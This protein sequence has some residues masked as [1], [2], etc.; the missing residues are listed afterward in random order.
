MSFNYQNKLIQQV[1]E[2]RRMVVAKYGAGKCRVGL[3]AADILARKDSIGGLVLILCPPRNVR[4]WITQ[5]RRWIPNQCPTLERDV[6]SPQL[7]QHIRQKGTDNHFLIL[8]NTRLYGNLDTL[9]YLKPDVII[10]DESTV[11]KN[12]KT[13]FFG[14]AMALVKAVPDAHRIAMTGDPTPE[15]ESEIW[16]Q[17]QFCY[18]DRNPYGRTYYQFMNRWFIRSDFVWTIRLEKS[19]EFMAVFDRYSCRMDEDDVAEH[20]AEVGVEEQ[21]QVF[22]YKPST[23]QMQL[24]EGLQREWALPIVVGAVDKEEYWHSISILH[25]QM[26]IASGFY[27]TKG[28]PLLEK[29]SPH[30]LPLAGRP[31]QV[32]LRAVVD[33]LLQNDHKRIVI[34]H[35]YKAD[36]A[37]ITAGLQG[38]APL[39][40]TSDNL[41]Q[42]AKEPKD[43]EEPLVIVL[44]LASARG[45]NDLTTASADIFFSNSFSQEVRNQAEKRLPRPGQTNRQVLHIDLAANDLADYKVV[46][47]LQTKQM[48]PER[49][50]TIVRET[51]EQT[52]Q[53]TKQ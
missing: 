8:A 3:L 40:G 1:V 14:N 21:Y 6:N 4:T 7:T 2:G 44:S 19:A 32:K 13:R 46:L 33:W 12:H 52:F 24:L 27:Y 22:M 49:A 34:W 36:L 11:M 50:N 15:H 23:L 29:S 53:E 28:D 37:I 17:F 45:I 31:K 47:A 42:F 39:I 18:G 26:Q 20:Q 30:Y 51:F 48:T 10:Y 5:A 41:D 38:L 25:K 43:G 9:A 35:L 16:S